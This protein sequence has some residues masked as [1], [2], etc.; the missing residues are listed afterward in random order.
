MKTEK[1]EETTEIEKTEETTELVEQSSGI[2][3]PDDIGG[4]LQE[5]SELEEQLERVPMMSIIQKGDGV[6]QIYCKKMQATW[7][8]GTFSVLKRVKSRLLWPEKFSKDNDPLCRSYDAITPADDIKG[9]TKMADSCEL[10][11]GSKKK[12]HCPY[13]DWTAGRTPPRCQ[14]RINLLLWHWEVQTPMWFTVYSTGLSPTK[15]QLLDPIMLRLAPLTNKLQGMAD[16]QGLSR[17]HP[18]MF[19][20]KLTTVLRENADGDAY[21][22]EWSDLQEMTMENKVEAAMFAYQLQHQDLKFEM[23]DEEEEEPG[24]DGF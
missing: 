12:H 13:A 18:C 7:E 4:F 23:E 17:A 21:I 24:T 11:V 14:E 16:N 1:T 22:P 5:E 2:T 9:A 20:A 19:S 15:N 10:I 8:S 3:L 6:G